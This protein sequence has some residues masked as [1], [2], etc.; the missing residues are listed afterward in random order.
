MRP[1]STDLFDMEVVALVKRVKQLQTLQSKMEKEKKKKDE[2][3]AK[4]KKDT[5][6]GY[7]KA[8]K[9]SRAPD[10]DHDPDLDS[11]GEEKTPEKKDEL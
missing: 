8:V 11:E 9:A 7:M 6:Y 2:T 3:I 5:G 4:V 1:G 10:P